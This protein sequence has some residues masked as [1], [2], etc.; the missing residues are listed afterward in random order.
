MC[1][2]VKPADVC[3]DGETCKPF[4]NGDMPVCEPTSGTATQDQSCV[5]VDCAPGYVCITNVFSAS[6]HQWC[7]ESS[8]CPAG[9]TCGFLDPNFYYNGTSYGYCR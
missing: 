4:T 6:C 3:A 5:S 8:E 2:P 7:H 9:K 1:D